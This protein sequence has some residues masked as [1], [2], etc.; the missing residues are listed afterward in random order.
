MYVKNIDDDA[1]DD[2]LREQFSHCGTITS[3]KLMR[4][5]KGISKGFG[6]VCFSTPEEANMAVNTLHGTSTSFIL[7]G[8]PP[9]VVSLFLP[10]QNLMYQP[11]GFRPE[12]RVNVFASPTRPAFQPIPSVNSLK[13]SSNQQV[14]LA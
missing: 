10:R 7:A 9:G 3:V 14:C 8:R 4:D 2:E 6:F 12:W 11:L 1:D 13:D 5:D